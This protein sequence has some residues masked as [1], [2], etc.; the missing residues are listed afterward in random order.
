MNPAQF[1]EFVLESLRRQTE[2]L[3]HTIYHLDGPDAI[4]HL[5]ALLTLEQ[6]NVIQWTHGAGKPDGLWEGWYEPIY[7]K[8]LAAGKSLLLFVADGEADRWIE[9]IDRLV[10]RFGTR[11][12]FLQFDRPMDE[13]DARRIMA[14]AEKWER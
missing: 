7:E 8:A 9:G 6:L 11:G 13:D 3:D 4:K 12:L 1:K 2:S 10:N 14:H 5:D